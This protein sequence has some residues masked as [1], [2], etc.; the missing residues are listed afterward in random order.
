MHKL[1]IVSEK[2]KITKQTL[3]NYQSTHFSFYLAAFNENC[4]LKAAII[5]AETEQT[6][7]SLLI[8]LFKTIKGG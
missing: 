1:L 4:K 3:N 2:G 6:H 7:K 8:L 5:V